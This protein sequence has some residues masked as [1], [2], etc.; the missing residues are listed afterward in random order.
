MQIDNVKIEK[1]Y[2][3]IDKEISFNKDM[4][5]LVGI[6]GSGKTSILNILNWII[7]PSLPNLCVTEFKTITLNLTFRNTKYEIVCK[8]YKATFH[9]K[10]KSKK[11]TF[12]PLI[13]KLQMSP[14]EIKN[15]ETL[16]T[17]LIEDYTGLGPEDK[18]KKT[19]ELVSKFPNPTIIGLDRNLYTEESSDQVY[20]EESFKGR[21]IRKRHS[22][23]ISPLDRVKEIINREYR[24]Q[25]NSILNLTNL[26]KNKLMLSAFDGS[27]TQK[28]LTTGIRYKLNHNQIEKAESQVTDY[29]QN[30]EVHNISNKEQK[31]IS[32]YFSQLKKI[33]EQYQE[34]PKNDIIRFLYSINANQFIKVRKLLTEFEKFENQ[35][36]K[37]MSQIQNYVD[38]LNSFF[39]DSAKKIIFKEDT[40]ELTFNIVGKNGKV[41]TEY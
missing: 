25:K 11:Y 32:N 4:T 41:L 15:D 37:T 29:F 9:Y 34:N 17:R 8:H 23:T 3:Y 2:G 39:E 22:T 30:F 27:I 24:K 12:N 35:T 18:E 33:T 13:V 36:V 28:D 6:N 26:L 16:R 7:S 31:T 14:A 20:F 21:R 10:I 40:S 1:L 38:T 19:W 5:I